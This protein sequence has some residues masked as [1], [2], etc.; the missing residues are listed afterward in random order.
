MAATD[1]A[2]N[3]WWIVFAAMLGL[4]VGQGSINVFAAGVFLKPVAQEFGFG[5]GEIST[6]IGLS[7]V[8]TA[9][10]TPFFGR[11]VDRLGVRPMLLWSIT[12][13]ALATAALSLLTASTVVLFLL[14]AISG[15]TAVGQNPTAYCKVITAW[16]DRQRGLALGLALAGVGLGTVI[17]PQLSNALIGHFGWR[18][19]YVGLGIAI[20][21]LAFLPVALF[22]REPAK[23]E[24]V[25]G[26]NLARAVAA[27]PGISFAEA[28]RT[29]RY[30][31][32]TLTFFLAATTIN[33]SLIH[34][35]SLLTDRGIPATVA[36]GAL[37]AAGLA[38]I[39][40]RIVAGYFIDKIF[41]PYIALLFLLSPMVGIAILATGMAVPVVGTILLGLGIGAE[42]DLMSFIISRYFGIRFFGALHG[43]M[44]A[45]VM[46]GNAV[47]ASILGWCFQL[48]HDYTPGFALFEVL[49][50][51][52]CVLIMTLGR[53]RYPA[54]PEAAAGE[55][56]EAR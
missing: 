33:G 1:H 20:F 48:L 39:G 13:F 2:W 53:Y 26:P 18:I 37:S 43:F 25:P 34:V 19:G 6:A 56:L 16:F 42:I 4:I 10:V 27:L 15:V 52:A 38:L 46:L 54:G 12:L 45:P 9:I 49:L 14:F 36:V 55:L 23:P 17:I 47:G 24:A 22:V 28:I 29:W 41:A 40:G 32:M 51:I 35:V 5:R 50:A 8:V 44:F 11:L 3:R 7:S 31:A 30:W 21:V